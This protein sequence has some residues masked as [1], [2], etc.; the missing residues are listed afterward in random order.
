MSII[1]D[2]SGSGFSA[3]VDS[4]NKLEVRST[5]QAAN[6]EASING[7]G[8]FVTSGAINLTSASASAMLW[9]QNADEFDYLID[10]LIFGAGVST[11]GTTN[12]CVVAA[13]INATGIGSGSGNPLTAINTNFG[14]KNQPTLTSSEIGAEAAT[15]TG[16]T[17]GPTF[18]FPDKITS[19]IDTRIILPKGTALAFTVT[20]PASNSGML[21]AVTLNI[22]K[23]I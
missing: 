15:I 12:M 21:A 7:D 8:Y 1:E 5:T 17:P 22:S 4:T 13:K 11:G 2:G 18:F 16:G 20:P 10:R 6:V 19:T 9:F 3:Q 14:S 23:V